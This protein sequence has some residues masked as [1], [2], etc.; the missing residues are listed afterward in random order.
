M[1]AT[2][3]TNPATNVDGVDGVLHPFYQVYA[4]TVINSALSGE[5][6]LSPDAAGDAYLNISAYLKAYS[7][8]SFIWPIQSLLH[9]RTDLML[10]F[11]VRFAER[12]GIT[13]QIKKLQSSEGYVTY[14]LPGGVG[15]MQLDEYNRHNNTFWDELQYHRHFLTHQPNNKQV[16]FLQVEKLFFL[17][18]QNI[19]QLRLRVEL[20]Y[21]ADPCTPE[22]F[23][24]STVTTAQWNIIELSF[25]FADLVE[26]MATPIDKV[27]R[28]SVW[29]IKPDG[30]QV[31][32]KRTYYVDHREE[33]HTHHFIWR[34]S[35][36]VYDSDLWAGKHERSVSSEKQI[37]SMTNRYS[38]A[39]TNPQTQVLK[40][41]EVEMYNASTGWAED[42][43]R[44]NWLREMIMSREVYEVVDGVL[45]PIVITTAEAHIQTT[46]KTLHNLHIEYTRAF[47]DEHFSQQSTISA[48]FLQSYNQGFVVNSPIYN[49]PTI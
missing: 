4:Q 47:T 40:S 39:A 1:G 9:N 38:F 7:Q 29:L 23:N 27:Y 33:M 6:L 11:W 41:G 35:Y 37:Y 15:H 3:T 28:F 22:T 8:S 25:S 49:I 18:Y 30:T 19:G 2:V 31:S 16:K 32:E 45:Y 34:N 44:I 13:P 21:F 17:N 12:Y 5:D 24:L 26:T 36:G 46:G 14:A 10:R 48:T 20:T 43:A 42:E